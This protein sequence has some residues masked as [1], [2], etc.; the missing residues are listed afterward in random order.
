MSVISWLAY[1]YKRAS[2]T[3]ITPILTLALPLIMLAL[4]CG[5]DWIAKETSV[6]KKFQTKNFFL[7]FI[8][9]LPLEI[10]FGSGCTV[11]TR[12]LPGNR[13]L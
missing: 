10:P 5:F 6:K 3:W 12:E 4:I 9:K 1:G 7:M 2:I 8:F 11:A 13:V